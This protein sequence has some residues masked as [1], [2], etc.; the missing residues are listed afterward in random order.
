MAKD[1]HLFAHVLYGVGIHLNLRERVPAAGDA[2]PQ[3]PQYVNE[4]A[5][6][7]HPDYG[8]T[9][10]VPQRSRGYALGLGEIER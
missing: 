2:V 8:R 3:V 9:L 10:R 1:C 6:A 7:D 4:V 5:G